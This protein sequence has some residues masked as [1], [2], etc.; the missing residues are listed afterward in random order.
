MAAEVWNAIFAGLTLVVF[1]VTAIAAF[2]QLR[3]LRVSNSLNGLITILEDWQKPELQR[4]VHFTRY[5]LPQ[6]LK[7]DAYFAQIA[8]LQS[9]NRE[10]HP[11]LHVC[12]YYEQLGAIVKYGMIDSQAL[13]D[14]GCGTITSL[15]RAVWPA[16]E[17]RR[18]GIDNEALCENFEYLAVLCQNWLDRYPRGAYPRGTPRW[19]DVAKG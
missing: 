7:D 6:K 16:L 2:V 10:E 18:R 19:P 12:D 8:S 13:L 14:V 9:L 1:V 4:W 17:A 15:W 3:H 11:W 5:E